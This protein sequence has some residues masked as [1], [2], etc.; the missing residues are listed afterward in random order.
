[1]VGIVLLP[2]ALNLTGSP[3]LAAP[4]FQSTEVR[5]LTDTVAGRPCTIPTGETANDLHYRVHSPTQAGDYPIVFGLAGNGYESTSTCV[6]AAKGI[7]RFEQLDSIMATWV[8]AGYVA[9]NIEYH[10][11]DD[12]LFG[13]ASYPGTDWG[14]AADG[15]SELNAK[16]AMEF[17]LANDPQRF[18]ADPSKGIVLFG[19]SAG[20]HSAH[21]VGN[22]GIDGYAISAVVGW[23]AMPEASKAGTKKFDLYMQTTTGSDV[24]DF[25]DAIHRITA[26]SPPQYISNSVDEFLDPQNAI[27]YYNT[28][29]GLLGGSKCYLRILDQT[30]CHATGC[31]KYAFGQPGHNDTTE[32]PATP[33][34][35][36]FQDT[37]AFA[38]QFVT[39]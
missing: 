24:F 14:T 16:V 13:D 28:C 29:V 4:A 38:D 19:G 6:N 36:L 22:T 34:S 37:I 7:E 39:H 33:G 23:S 5:Y 32:P 8:R 27:D 10:G 18:G 15:I 9:V 35:T 26:S 3:A 1:M 25:G 20:G 17:F 30:S 21:L 11:Y 31:S 12:G 2:V